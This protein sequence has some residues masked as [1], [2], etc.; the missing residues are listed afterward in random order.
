[1][2]GD[3]GVAD[4]EDER[5]VLWSQLAGL[6]GADRGELSDDSVLAALDDLGLRLLFLCELEDSVLAA[7]EAGDDLSVDIACSLLRGASED[8]AV[9]SDRDVTTKDGLE[10]TGAF[11]HGSAGNDSEDDVLDGNHV[12]GM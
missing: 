1:M 10:D 4:Q 9:S 12:C 8:V 2:E 6:I 11:D 3:R 5:R 7:L